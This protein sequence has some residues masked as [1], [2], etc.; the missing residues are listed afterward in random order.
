MREKRIRINV[1]NMLRILPFLKHG[2]ILSKRQ[3]ARIFS[4]LHAALCGGERRVKMASDI[5]I[6][7]VIAVSFFKTIGYCV[8]TFK[9]KKFFGR[10]G[11]A[12]LAAM[13]LAVAVWYL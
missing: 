10:A 2:I 8:Y 12:V 13:L 7:A 11:V 5:L 4:M 1:K 6:Y 9:T 3:F